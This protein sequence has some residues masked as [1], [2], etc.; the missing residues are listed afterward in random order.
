MLLFA[1]E[2]E[3]ETLPA[4]C[5][6][7]IQGKRYNAVFTEHHIFFHWFDE[8]MNVISEE[9]IKRKFQLDRPVI[10]HE[11]YEIVLFSGMEINCYWCNDGKTL[12]QI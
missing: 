4:G 1:P 5:I 10:C 3:Y 11:I 2:E 9:S 12:I 8:K 6:L 7:E